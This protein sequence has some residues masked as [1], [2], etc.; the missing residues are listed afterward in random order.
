VRDLPQVIR[1]LTSAISAKQNGYERVFA[2]LAAQACLYALPGRGDGKERHVSGFNVDDV[3][4]AKIVGGGVAEATV[5]RGVVCTR[6]SEGTVKAVKNAHVA[7]YQHGTKG[8]K[9]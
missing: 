5:L 1:C 2:P 3:R 7:V 9:E 6:D 4:V 8:W